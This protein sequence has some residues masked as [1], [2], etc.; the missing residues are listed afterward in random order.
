MA[1]L[2]LCSMITCPTAHSPQVGKKG[3]DCSQWKSIY[4]RSLKIDF[5]LNIVNAQKF[6]LSVEKTLQYALQAPFSHLLSNCLFLSPSDKH[7]FP[8]SGP[9][10]ESRNNSAIQEG[11]PC[12]QTTGPDRNEFCGRLVKSMSAVNHVLCEPHCTQTRQR[13]LASSRFLLQNR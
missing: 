5:T 1:L 9:F 10:Y 8:Q 3:F 12:P 7:R 13:C 4:K 11:K 6:L 2:S